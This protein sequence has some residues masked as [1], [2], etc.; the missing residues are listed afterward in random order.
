MAK[1]AKTLI[2][3]KAEASVIE[4]WAREEFGI[5]D[6]AVLACLR[7]AYEDWDRAHDHHV[8]V[9]DNQDENRS[10]AVLNLFYRSHGWKDD[11]QTRLVFAL[12]KTN[13]LFTIREQPLYE[14][15]LCALSTLDLGSAIQTE[16]FGSQH[17]CR[18][19][20]R[21]EP[22]KKWLATELKNIGQNAGEDLC[23]RVAEILGIDENHRYSKSPEGTKLK[24][25]REWAAH[26]DQT[27]ARRAF[28]EFVR[29]LDQRALR[30]VAVAD[31]MYAL[32]AYEWLTG[33]R[34][35]MKEFAGEKRLPAASPEAIRNRQD[36]LS[37]WPG[38][39]V[40]LSD[41]KGYFDGLTAALDSGAPRVA[42]LSEFLGK[43]GN[44]C[45]GPNADKPVSIEFVRWLRGK[46][47]KDFDGLVEE[48]NPVLPHIVSAFPVAEALPREWR[49]RDHK[50]WHGLYSIKRH[51]EALCQATGKPFDKIVNEF[52][53]LPRGGEGFPGHI[54]KPS[55][56]V[57]ESFAVN[58]ESIGLEGFGGGSN[59]LHFFKAAANPIVIP[60][61]L[62]RA[63]QTDAGFPNEL[64][65]WTNCNPAY[66]GLLSGRVSALV[67]NGFS[68]A[69]LFNMAQ[70]WH[71][72]AGRLQTRTCRL[73]GEYEWAPLIHPM[74]LPGGVKA[75][76][77]ISTRELQAEGERMGNCVGGY[78]HACAVRGHHIVSLESE[79]GSEHSLMEIEELPENLINVIQHVGF[80]NSD[81][82]SWAAAATECLVSGINDRSI[83]ANWDLV[84][85]ER[86]KRAARRAEEAQ[87][88][89]EMLIGFDP[90]DLAACDNA[91]ESWHHEMRGLYPHDTREQ[92]LE[93]RG[94][95]AV[96]EKE[97]KAPAPIP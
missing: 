81:P 57:Q 5:Q 60:A 15:S 34:H 29:H 11:I 71:E 33:A 19:G 20:Y 50:E 96:L 32:P 95:K 52:A 75:K 82:P 64:E 2:S 84:T 73:E 28:F 4:T 49:P 53:R 67:Y 94:I 24:K 77:L 36:T 26:V 6:E 56:S 74:T 17:M 68:L 43:R 35:E 93:E 69:R 27:K 76:A 42:V 72:R 31:Y 58:R 12:N 8:A 97:I 38:L 44:G 89:I 22:S 3:R 65:Q 18:G 37:I 21:H 70:R 78:T 23:E 41:Y 86:T 47:R 39:I 9:D 10:N 79:D 63:R 91:Y 16:D 80:H 83:A 54:L 51:L 13:A 62:H 40:F 85:E 46:T 30:L 7:R 25:L 14:E 66:R 1:K 45:R 88:Q 61:I 87:Q 90:Y 59:L 48:V 92:F 55:V